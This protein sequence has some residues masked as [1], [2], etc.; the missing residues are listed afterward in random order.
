MITTAKKMN[1]VNLKVAKLMR[2]VGFYSRCTTS[3]KYLPHGGLRTKNK[4]AVVL[5][6]HS[7]Y[8]QANPQKDPV[9]SD[10]AATLATAPTLD[11]AKAWLIKRFGV[12][13]YTIPDTLRL[14]KFLWYPW[15]KMIG[16]SDYRRVVKNGCIV[17]FESEWEAT[18][19]ALECVLDNILKNH[20]STSNL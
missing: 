9:C 2:Q 6:D 16:N 7:P 10:R 20:G 4:P 14:D 12:A 13:V 15:F 5:V 17:S 11:V 3:W 1:C 8:S 18:N 19:Y